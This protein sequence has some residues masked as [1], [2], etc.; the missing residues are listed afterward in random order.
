M[1]INTINSS[2][3]FIV[4]RFLSTGKSGVVASR[5]AASLSSVGI[6]AHYVHA[7]EWLHGDLGEGSSG[8]YKWVVFRASE[9][10]SYLHKA[11]V[12]LMDNIMCL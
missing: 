11:L 6:P 3:L 4:C 5:F 10:F 7:T 12:Q 1:C 2:K 9:W 8:I